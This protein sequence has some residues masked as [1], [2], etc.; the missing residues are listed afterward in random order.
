[1]SLTL[2]YLSKSLSIENH[3]NSRI[4]VEII[5]RRTYKEE[6]QI[7]MLQEKETRHRCVETID[8]SS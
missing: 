7:N 3:V 8:S 2:G 5:E 1:M 6:N 4:N